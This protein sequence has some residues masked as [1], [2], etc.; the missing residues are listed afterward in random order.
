M[1]YFVHFLKFVAGFAA[2]LLA[3]LVVIRLVS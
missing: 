2:I 3:A 1:P